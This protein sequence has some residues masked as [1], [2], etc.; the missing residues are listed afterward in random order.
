MKEHVYN[1][2]NTTVR[3]ME[4]RLLSQADFDT[5]LHAENLHDALSQLK[6]TRYDFDLEA[7]ESQKNFDQLLTD[8]LKKQYHELLEV[9][10]DPRIINLFA[11]RY[12]Y[13]NLKVLLKGQFTGRDL[14]HLMIPIGLYSKASLQ[15]LVE[16]G[17][18]EHLPDVM[19]E[20][21]SLALKD[22]EETKRVQAAD[23]YMDTYYFKHLR[24]LANELLDS[25]FNYLV[26][27]MI[28]LKNLSTLIRARQGQHSRSFLMTVLSSSGTVSKLDLVNS[29]ES[30]EVKDALPL[31]EGKDYSKDLENIFANDDE[32]QLAMHLETLEN[33]I[34]HDFLADAMFEGFGPMPVLAYLFAVEM[35]V[36]NI[37]L[38]LV[39]KDNGFSEEELRERMNPINVA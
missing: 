39:G 28:D 9:V 6:K 20:G 22:Y 35:E 38:I 34:V 15:N 19:V 8:E 7:L 32:R 24:T 5:L 31:F 13:H 29:T 33:R 1:A 16:T 26:N 18:S 10:P 27:I 14:S 4:T 17:Q 37:R 30:G 25:R 12:S 36:L 23:V 21:V 11:L 3:L 2:V